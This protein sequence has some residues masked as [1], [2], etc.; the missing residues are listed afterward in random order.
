LADGT[1]PLATGW[2]A[3][4]GDGDE[5][6]GLLAKGAVRLLPAAMAVP[7]CCGPEPGSLKPPNLMFG[8]LR[9]APFG[10]APA[11][12]EDFRLCWPPL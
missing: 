9:E 1:P 5:A 11:A 3:A 4:E 12:I 6:L 2:V 7:G 8:A 10:I